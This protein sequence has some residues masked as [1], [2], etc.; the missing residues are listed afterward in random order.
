MARC[1]PPLGSGAITARL[2][3]ESRGVS[4]L[5][6]TPPLHFPLT[7]LWKRHRV[8]SLAARRGRRATDLVIGGAFRSRPPGEVRSSS[9]EVLGTFSTISRRLLLLV[10][11]ERDFRR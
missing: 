11:I 6:A 1:P 10:I 9:L 4:S 3:L 2:D 8:E 5:A 7:Q